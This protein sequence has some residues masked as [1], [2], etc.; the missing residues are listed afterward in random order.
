MLLPRRFLGLLFLLGS[1]ALVLSAVGCGRQKE[2][3]R[4]LLANGDADCDA[5]DDLL[6][7]PASTL[8]GDDDDKVDRC[9]PP[10]GIQPSDSRCAPRTTPGD[11]DGDGDGTGTGGGGTGEGGAT[12][13]PEGSA[14]DY[15]S[16]CADHFICGR[17]WTC[18]HE[19]KET[20]DCP[21]GFECTKEF[22]CE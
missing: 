21:N 1:T 14:C 20:R 22:T 16:D 2:G 12:G 10:P 6:C 17:E 9:C 7:T 3:E 15:N 19:C 11:G 4:C 5:N 13:A 18:V 8:R